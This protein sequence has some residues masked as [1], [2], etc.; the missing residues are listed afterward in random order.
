MRDML[1][2][3]PTLDKNGN[4]KNPRKPSSI[5]DMIYDPIIEPV[6]SFKIPDFILDSLDQYVK[7]ASSANNYSLTKSNEALLALPFLINDSEDSNSE[8]D[9]N[10]D[11][12]SSSAYSSFS[13]F[14]KNRG[15]DDCLDIDDDKELVVGFSNSQKSSEFTKKSS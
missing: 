10:I 12:D 7:T 6:H 15:K 3:G 9:D 13:S 2:A 14:S 8:N 4:I 1:L 5:K 11:S